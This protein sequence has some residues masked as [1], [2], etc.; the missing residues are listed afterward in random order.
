[1]RP[2]FSFQV[3][4]FTFVTNIILLLVINLTLVICH[5]AL[6]NLVVEEEYSMLNFFTHAS[7]RENTSLI[8]EYMHLDSV[9]NPW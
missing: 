7:Y 3:L 8:K 6:V 1:M 5:D 2:D 4:P 9:C